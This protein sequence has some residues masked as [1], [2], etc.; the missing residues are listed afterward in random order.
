MKYFYGICLL[1]IGLLVVRL[2]FFTKK[3]IQ[4]NEPYT[5]F[6]NLKATTIDGKTIKM[7]NYKDKYI[8]I[9]NTASKCG[10]TYQY[11]DLEKLY[12]QNKDKLVILA[13]PSND[14][15]WQ[16]PD[17]NKKIKTFCTT[18]FNVSFPLF[19]KSSVKGKNKNS[20]YQWLTDPKKNGWSSSKP[21][22][23]FNKYLLDKKGN[24]IKHFGSK[25]KPL[26]PKITSLIK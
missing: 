12:Q 23:N 3:N 8:L 6:Y 19:S 17:S 2:Q 9:V 4:K 14:F 20:I 18:K 15:L 13:F 21:S 24:L 25:V 26:D 1:I 5:S 11:E 7:S 22:W 16:E 10:Y